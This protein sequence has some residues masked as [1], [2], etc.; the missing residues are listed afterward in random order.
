VVIGPIEKVGNTI[1][2]RYNAKETTHD[3]LRRRPEVMTKGTGVTTI[4]AAT[5]ARFIG[6]VTDFSAKPESR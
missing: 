5:L 2:G 3:T 6:G 1:F 4:G